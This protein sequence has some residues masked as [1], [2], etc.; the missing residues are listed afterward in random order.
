MARPHHI[1]VV[2]HGTWHPTAHR[3]GGWWSEIK[4]IPGAA[5]LAALT[6][7]QES[8]PLTAIYPKAQ[9]VK[10]AQLGLAEIDVANAILLGLSRDQSRRSPSIG[11]TW[12]P[13]YPNTTLIFLLPSRGSI[14]CATE[15]DAREALPS[16]TTKSWPT[17]PVSSVKKFRRFPLQ[18]HAGYW[19]F[20]E[21]TGATS[22]A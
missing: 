11:S 2:G 3:P 13:G 10:A 22:A 7:R 6:E 5:Q 17:S 18:R 9:C 1:Q 12:K 20:M 21:W 8:P 4:K 16:R 14:C 15:R 19:M